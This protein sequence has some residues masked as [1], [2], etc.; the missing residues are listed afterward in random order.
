MMSVKPRPL[1]DIRYYESMDVP[2]PGR[3][4]PSSTT[5]LI[6]IPKTAHRIGQRIACMLN[7]EGYSVGTYDHVY[8][9][10]T[11]VMPAGKIVPTEFGVEWWQRYVACGVT[12]NFRLLPE[13]EKLRFIESA[14]FDIL[15]TLQPEQNAVLDSARDRIKKFGA[16]TRILRAA[17]DTKDYCFEIWFDVPPWRETAYLYVT[18]RNSAS[19]EITEASPLPLRDYEDAFPLVSSIT[20]TKGILRL[21]PRKS[22]RAGLSIKNYITP[23]QFNVAEFVAHKATQ[24]TR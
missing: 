7:A 3:S 19:G 20:F 5:E 11:P 13:E 18:A 2:G 12:Q 17:K 22:L 10:F 14:T 4:L 15:R 6:G 21:N 9:A 24:A 16:R 1:K 23:I 8:V